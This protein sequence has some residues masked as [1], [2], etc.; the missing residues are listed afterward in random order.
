MTR[1]DGPRPG[2][3]MDVLAN[4]KPAFREN[5][6]VTAGNSCPLHDGAAAVLIVSDERADGE[7]PGRLPDLGVTHL[8]M[9]LTPERIWRAIR[10][11]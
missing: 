11:H 1:D 5:G 7:V 3:T 6:T 2:T 4:L 8:E 10:A 9:P